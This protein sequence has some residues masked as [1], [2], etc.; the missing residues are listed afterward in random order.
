[1]EKN[2]L[3]EQ[4]PEKLRELAFELGNYLRRVN[5]QMPKLKES[6]KQV[7]WPDELLASD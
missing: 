4:N 2:N 5:A 3:A 1:M 7:P 6:G